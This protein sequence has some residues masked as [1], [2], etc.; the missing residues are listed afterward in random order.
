MIHIG[1]PTKTER[2]ISLSNQAT[3]IWYQGR[4]FSVGSSKLIARSA[5]IGTQKKAKIITFSVSSAAMV[6]ILN[7]MIKY[8]I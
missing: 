5:V 2:G 8:L 7:S 6:P 3:A 1:K 4:F